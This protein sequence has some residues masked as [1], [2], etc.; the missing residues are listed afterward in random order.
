MRKKPALSLV[1]ALLVI[2]ALALAAGCG[3]NQQ[4][5]V[6][7]PHINSVS[8]ESGPPGTEVKVFGLHFGQAQGL[9][10]VYF[11]NTISEVVSWS[12]DEIMARVP[13]EP[14]A[15]SY[16]VTVLTAKG[17]SNQVSFRV[18]PAGEPR[19]KPEPEPEPEPDKSDEELV[20]EAVTRWLDRGGYNPS[21]WKLFNVKISSAD[22]VWALVSAD[23]TYTDAPPEIDFLLAKR[24]GKWII[25][26]EGTQW[27]ASEF[28]APSD[29]D[30]RNR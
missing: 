22:P 20:E 29:V 18:T 23:N 10:V 8:P 17:S 4:A 28:N 1:V 26:A 6:E 21:H 19:S 11:G 25:V 15:V 13:S 27:T 2:L 9:G 12:E 5:T 16:P 14:A 3:E 30:P 7:T 24:D